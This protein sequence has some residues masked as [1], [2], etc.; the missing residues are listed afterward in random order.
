[1]RTVW[2][3]MNLPSMKADRRQTTDSR[4]EGKMANMK[5]FSSIL[6]FYEGIFI[7]F[8][9]H[10]DFMSVTYRY[11]KP[12]TCT[13]WPTGRW[14]TGWSWQ[15]PCKRDH[16]LQTQVFSQNFISG[17]LFDKISPWGGGW[18]G[19][20]SVNNHESKKKETNMKAKLKKVMKMS[21]WRHFC[22]FWLIL[23]SCQ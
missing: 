20:G 15:S 16:W 3:M 11:V 22:H 13:G 8:V 6:C 18:K 2:G 19:T 1:M 4:H 10:Y 9:G 21:S 5:A 7:T 12:G 17:D 14:P 23:P